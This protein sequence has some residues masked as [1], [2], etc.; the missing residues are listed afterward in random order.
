[1][2]YW[3][4][5]VE[6]EIE[7]PGDLGTGEISLEIFLLRGPRL[8]SQDKFHLKPFTKKME[9]FGPGLSILSLI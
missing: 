6:S 4:C 9:G 1:M 5:F 8:L 7:V 3:P 2:R